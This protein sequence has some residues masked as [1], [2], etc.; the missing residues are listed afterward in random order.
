MCL[1]NKYLFLLLLSTFL[2]PNVIFTQQNTSFFEYGVHIGS[3]APH[4]KE[5]KSLVKEP[6]VGLDFTYGI[7]KSPD[8]YMGQVFHYPEYGV[9]IYVGTTGSWKSIGPVIA[10]YGFVR[11]LLGSSEKREYYFH[12]GTGL[13]YFFH[14][15]DSILNPSNTGVSSHINLF[16]NFKLMGNWQL[17]HDKVFF[18]ALSL[19][20][21]S[22]GSVKKP[23]NGLNY[24]TLEAGIKQTFFSGKDY[25]KPFSLPDFTPVNRIYV[26][27]GIGQKEHDFRED[28]FFTSTVTLGYTRQYSRKRRYGIG[29]DWM[30]D[31]SLYRP[32]WGIV[33]VRNISRMGLHLSHEFLFGKLAMVTQLAF[34]TYRKVNVHQRRYFRI[35]LRY[36]VTPWLFGNL[37]LRSH[38]AKADYLEAGFGFALP[39][40]RK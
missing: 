20:H 26:V 39:W 29:W 19:K 2:L 6:V 28:H 17:T 10:P 21:A 30:Y 1:K 15:Y 34:Y 38:N 36:E 24:I 9:G 18:G 40:S 35:G 37:T 13:S 25:S 22:N 27:G 31:E 32:D 12:V 14:T 4:H 11:F 5:M 3:L 8:S 7:R 16:V 23:N 33:G